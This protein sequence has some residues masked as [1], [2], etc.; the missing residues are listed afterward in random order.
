[1]SSLLLAQDL[2][3]TPDTNNNETQPTANSDIKTEEVKAAP[4]TINTENITSINITGNENI[5]NDAILNVITTKV[6]DPWNVSKI[7]TDINA[8]TDMGVFSA[9]T[10]K[11]EERPGGVALTFDLVENPKVTKIIVT[12][13]APLKLEDILSILK[14]K[15]GM[16][17]NE[18]ILRN[19]FRAIGEL[20]AEK[21]YLAS[22]TEQADVDPETGVVT[23][24]ILVFKV[25]KITFEGNKKTKNY[26]LLRE[27][28]T[29]SGDYYNY[30]T[31]AADYTK[32]YNLGFFE[33]LKQHQMQEGDTY[34]TLDINIPLV[35]KNT[36]SFNVGAG[37]SSTRKLVG[38]L[39]LS[40]TNLMGTG[41]NVSATWEQG[42]RSGYKGGASWELNYTEPWIDKQNTTLNVSLYNKIV[43]R[44]T[45][46]VWS[47]SSLPE[48]ADYDERH[49]GINLTLSRPFRKV[50]KGFL[51]LKYDN[52]TTNPS[53][54]QQ[55]E[56]WKIMQNGAVSSVNLTVNND[57]RDVILDPKS[58]D[59][60]SV[61]LEFGNVDGS[62]YAPSNYDGTYYKTPMEGT[63]Y[64][65]IGEYRLYHSFT[66]KKTKSATMKDL[67]ASMAF[68]L[69]GGISDGTLPFFEQ[70]FVG[71]ADTLRG[72]DDDRYWGRYL[73]ASSIEYRQPILDYLTV[74]A[75][76]DYADAW[77]SNDVMIYNGL[78]QS[79]S[80]KGHLGYGL[81]ARFNTPLGN[82]RLDWGFGTE[83][84]KVHF[85]MGQTF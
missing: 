79:N 37:Y 24:P 38:T 2:P 15:E 60:R 49:E 69:K 59:Y 22:V 28:Q 29:K 77:G 76:T 64:K 23:I 47:S 18:N 32:I 4:E 46:G 20:Y 54:L 33:D 57:N 26:V 39:R 80:F 31:I 44:F 41:R 78:E 21:G 72:Y 45:S 11:R 35:E 25:G 12:N 36:G 9:V 75:F 81:G 56:L 51:S 5:N 7:Q 6:G 27:M 67:R 55:D 13:T 73:L 58:G 50:Y 14:T 10:Y 8:I 3:A 68:K 1:M 34:G 65:S 74:V 48:D 66:K 52:V 62:K 16:L 17:L 40:D 42:T 71:G 85:S 19:D 83:G 82:I 61:S 84:N 53:L 70:Y 43:Y 63:F 30:N